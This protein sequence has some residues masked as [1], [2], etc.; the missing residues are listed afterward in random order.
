M[1]TLELPNYNN[2]T[3]ADEKAMGSPTDK[4]ADGKTL[5]QRVR[6]KRVLADLSQ[7][8]LA[9]MV[10]VTRQTIVRIETGETYPNKGTLQDIASALKVDVQEITHGPQLGKESFFAHIER[11]TVTPAQMARMIDFFRPSFTIM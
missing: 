11:D 6:L 1:P 9:E 10:K 8:E 3:S 5:G 7:Q 2:S 4:G